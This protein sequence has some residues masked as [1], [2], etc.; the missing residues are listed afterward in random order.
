MIVAKTIKNQAETHVAIRV[1]ELLIEDS[2]H[3]RRSEI[4]ALLQVVIDMR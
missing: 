4:D 2:Q 1:P 3:A